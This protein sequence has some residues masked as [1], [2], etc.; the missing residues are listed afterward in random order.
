MNRVLAERVRPVHVVLG[1]AGAIVAG[2]LLITGIA[3]LTGFTQLGDVLEGAD[4]RWLGVCAGGQIAVFAGYTFALRHAVESE[5]GTAIPPRLAVRIVFASFASTQVFAFGG[6]AGLA[7]VYWALTRLGMSRGQAAVR[8][9]GLS[10]AVYFVF[11]GIGLG[12]AALALVRATAPLSMTVPWLVVVPVVIA[13]ARWFTDGSRIGRWTSRRNAMWQRALATGVGAAAWVR[14]SA[15]D[16]SRWPVF[17]WAACYWFGDIAS[18]WAA[19]HAFGGKPALG[20]LT[21]VYATGYLVNSLPI[22]LIA[23][24]GVDA[25]TTFLLQAVGV[26]LEIAL[27]GIVAHRVFAFWLPVMPGTFFAVTLP[28]LGRRLAAVRASG[29]DVVQYPG[30]TE[31]TTGSATP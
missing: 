8:L 27:V 1:V 9:I 28:R 7:I 19:L 11:A 30:P 2:A 10:T 6:L 17:G 20:T 23:T 25:A 18:L 4:L 14:R 22:P 24:G 12:A 21:L 15:A 16:R 29:T 3:R 26:P 31:T 13:A 5:G